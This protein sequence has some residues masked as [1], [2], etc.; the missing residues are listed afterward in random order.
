M[1]RFQQASLNSPQS[2]KKNWSSPSD[3]ALSKSRDNSFEESRQSGSAKSPAAF[4]PRGVSS[5][6]GHTSVKE[7]QDGQPTLLRVKYKVGRVIG[8]GKFAVVRECTEKARKIP[9]ALKMINKT[10]VKEDYTALKNEVSILRKVKHENIVQLVEEF[11]TPTHHYLIFEL[12]NG[13]DLFELISQTNNYCEQDASSM[14][15]DICRGVSHLH[16]L[17]IVHRDIKP[18]NILVHKTKT[19]QKILKLADM[20]LATYATEPLFTVCGT[21]TYVAP[22]VVAEIGYGLKAD[23][24]SIG[25][26][27]YILLCGFPPF[28][29]DIDDQDELFDKIL[30]GKFEFVSPY[31]D[32]VTEQAK[33]LIR[34]M[35]CLDVSKR[36]TADEL[37]T[38]P[39]IMQEAP[40][41]T[42]KLD[43]SVSSKIVELKNNKS[44][45]HSNSGCAL[46]N[47][48]LD[49]SSRYFE[50]RKHGSCDSPKPDCGSKSTDD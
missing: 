32:D 21:P 23:I 27:T 19:E 46:T 14:I 45:E 10:K 11:E 50:G 31:W 43:Q 18:E 37:L 2:V 8:E 5:S 24:W 36:P 12:V 6:N 9:F 48:A 28:S 38:N 29:S 47:T 30:E 20:G 42:Q 13:G 15:S 34:S 16:G 39:W 35:L 26:L 1:L 17:N 41:T 22:E 7:P 3:K 44:L 33:E 25:V 4:Q 40:S 49:K